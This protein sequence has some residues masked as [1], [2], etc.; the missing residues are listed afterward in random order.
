MQ[1]LATIGTAWRMDKI[2]L[3]VFKGSL[4]AFLKVSAVRTK[5]KEN[6]GAL[7]FYQA[8]GYVLHPF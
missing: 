6:M 5:S 7:R 4:S 3:T 1:H 2:M 8:N